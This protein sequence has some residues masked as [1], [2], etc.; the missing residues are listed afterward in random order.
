MTV[1]TATWLTGLC[2]IVG[3]VARAAFTGWLA[4]AVAVGFVLFGLGLWIDLTE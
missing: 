3:G 1:S 4:V 2:L